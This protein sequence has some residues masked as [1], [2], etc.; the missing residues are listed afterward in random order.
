MYIEHYVFPKM[1]LSSVNYL[2]AN[3]SRKPT[4]IKG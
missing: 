3:L 1:N 4:Y 2:N